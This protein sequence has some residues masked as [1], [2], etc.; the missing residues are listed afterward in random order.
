MKSIIYSL[1]VI[2]ILVSII[3]IVISVVGQEA[4]IWKNVSIQEF[5]FKSK[6][7]CV[8]FIE[9]SDGQKLESKLT[10]DQKNELVKVLINKMADLKLELKKQ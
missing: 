9:M 6:T 4:I 8:I 7:N 5:E 3:T 2:A 1:C 10:P